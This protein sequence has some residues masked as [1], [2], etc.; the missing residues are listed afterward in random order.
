MT[1]NPFKMDPRLDRIVTRGS[2]WLAFAPLALLV[3]VYLVV[4]LFRH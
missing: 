4:L 2:A 1:G 3:L